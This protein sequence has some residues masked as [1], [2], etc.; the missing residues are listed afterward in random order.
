MLKLSQIFARKRTPQETQS[1][2]GAALAPS[3]IILITA[4][5]L[6]FMPPPTGLEVSAWHL[7]IIFLGTIIGIILKPLPMGAIA[8]LGLSLC[9]ITNLIPLQQSLSSFSSPIV[10]LVLSAF[11]IARGFV[12]TGLGSRIAYYFMTFLGRSSLGLSYGLVLTDFF[13]SPVI[14]SNTARGGGIIFPIVQS[15]S[16]EYGSSPNTNSQRKIGAFLTQVAFQANLVTSAMFLTAFAGNPLAAKLAKE[17]GVIMNWGTWAIAGIVPGLVHLALLPLFLFFIYPPTLKKTPEAPEL[18]RKKLKEMGPLSFHEITMLL[19]F[20]LLL[21]L[22]IFGGNFGVEPTTAALLGLSLL[23]FTG[24]LSWDDLL[25]EK[26]AWDTFF[27]LAILLG[28]A[29]ALSDY[30]I[31]KWFGSGVENFVGLL[32]KPVAFAVLSILYFYCH[33]FFASG[34]AH[35]T[36]LYVMFLIAIVSTGIPA[37]LATFVLAVFASLSSG[38]THYGTGAAPVFF[39]GNFIPVRT[40]WRLGF[41]CSLLTLLVWSVVGGLWWKF[42]GYW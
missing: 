8:T 18:A 21:V 4:F 10:W 37:P 6:W 35:I 22:W 1:W 24:V 15:L 33:Y 11:F 31:I 34:T 42:L 17:V 7:L 9:V 14:P 36:S 20:A 13:L 41:L 26:A 23:L 38:L 19:I 40:W 16:N 29:G 3:F 32:S 2:T 25:Q 27:W 39:G 5:A 12:K 28:L 30:G